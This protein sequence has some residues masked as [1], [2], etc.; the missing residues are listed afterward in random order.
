MPV[1]PG[2]LQGGRGVRPTLVMQRLLIQ[3]ANGALLVIVL[4]GI[5]A[6]TSARFG[7]LLLSSAPKA[8]I[9]TLWGL[10]LG[11]VANTMTALLLIKGRKERLLCWKWTGSFASLLLVEY[12]FIHGYFDFN[13][14]R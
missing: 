13:W 12:L 5:P 9:L 7:S 4:I 2:I 8:Q 14:L 1:R 3:C 10:A 6:V 11:A